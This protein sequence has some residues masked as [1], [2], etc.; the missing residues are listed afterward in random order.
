M[1]I[2]NLFHK[3]GYT[4]LIKKFQSINTLIK[5]QYHFNIL[6]IFMGIDYS[7]NKKGK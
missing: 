2:E 6:N 3:S 7:N 4:I 5:F 1:I